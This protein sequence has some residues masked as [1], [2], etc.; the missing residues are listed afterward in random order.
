MIYRL[1]P[2]GAILRRG[3]G[4][5]VTYCINS[6]ICNFASSRNIIDRASSSLF[7]AL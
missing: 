1:V 2:I 4:N 5:T 7:T 3:K 6:F